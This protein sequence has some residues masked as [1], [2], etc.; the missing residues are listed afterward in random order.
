MA[1]DQKRNKDLVRRINDEVWGEGNLDLIDDHVAE[2]YVEHSNA[3]PEDIHGPEG[4]KANVEM[5]RTAL[6]DMEVTTEH[7]VAE[8]DLVVNHYTITGTHDGPFMGIEPTGNEVR[9]S[10]VG[11]IRIADG[12][13]VE[14]WGVVDIFGLMQQI[15][16]IS[17]G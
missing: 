7:L 5:A 2:D 10:G 12:K 3:A 17:A 4:Y 11:I 14:D 16:V 13:I 6:P 15:G 8:G 1:S 9:F